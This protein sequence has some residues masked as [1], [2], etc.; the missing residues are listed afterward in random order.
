MACVIMPTSFFIGVH[1]GL[2]GVSL[3]WIIGYSI[4]FFSTLFMISPVI[5]MKLR[6]FFGA[7]SGPALMGAL[8]Y[9]GVA[10]ARWLLS[11]WEVY[12]G[13]ALPVMIA[14]GAC[15]YAAGMWLFFRGTVREVWG[16]RR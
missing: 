1:W 16:M 9:G 2:K 6:Q 14:V 11:Q 4:W 8:M 5:G 15:I 12:T 3:A 10:G 7:V 13:V